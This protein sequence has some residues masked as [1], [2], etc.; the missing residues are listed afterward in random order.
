MTLGQ[1]ATPI[2]KFDGAS[3]RPVGREHS[4]PYFVVN[5]NLTVVSSVTLQ[6]S[7]VLLV[8]P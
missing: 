5:S 4:L 1:T 3:P 8:S 7:G 2:R 6:L